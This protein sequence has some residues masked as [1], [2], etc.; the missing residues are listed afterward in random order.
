MST[1]TFV[2]ATSADPVV[3]DLHRQAMRLLNDPSLDRRRREFHMRRLQSILIEHQAK[4]AAKA[5]SSLARKTSREQVSRANR[6]QGVADPSQVVARRK[7]FGAAVT[8][9][10]QATEQVEQVVDAAPRATVVGDKQVPGRHRPVLTLK[11]A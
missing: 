6:N 4:Q 10:T 7:E 11:R 3:R 1:T 8:E 9:W 5:A 2:E